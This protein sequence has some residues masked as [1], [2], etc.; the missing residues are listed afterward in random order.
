MHSRVD[1]G[2]TSPAAHRSGREPLDSS[3]SSYSNRWP[4]TQ[5]LPVRKQVRLSLGDRSQ[6]IVRTPGPSPELL[7]FPGS[8]LHQLPVQVI[9]RRVQRRLV[10]MPKVVDPTA[11]LGTEHSRQVVNRFVTPVLNT[12]TSD[13]LPDRLGR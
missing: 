8:P 11:K 6:P 10:E 5:Q 9:E 1:R 7:E 3:G 13:L 2:R 12:P 4:Q